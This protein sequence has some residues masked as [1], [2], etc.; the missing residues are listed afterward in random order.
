MAKAKPET[1]AEAPAVTVRVTLATPRGH[2]QTSV[3]RILCGKTVEL[4]DAEAS[5]AMSA[6]LV[7][8]VVD[9]LPPTD[10]SDAA[11]DD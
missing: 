11:A 4:P 2:L 3:G 7:E 10:S 6:G 1:K 8:R 5:A 9:P